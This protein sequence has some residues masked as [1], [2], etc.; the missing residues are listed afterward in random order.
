MRGVLAA[1]LL[2]A[3]PASAHEG[4]VHG[5]PEEAARHRAGDAPPALAAPAP[6]GPV[7]ALPFELGGPFELVDHEG[8]ARTQADPDGHLQ[9]LFFGYA[10]CP[11]ICAVAMPMMGQVVDALAERGVAATPVMITVDPERDTPETMDAPLARIHADFVGLTGDDAAL[12][13]AWDAFG[14]ERTLV[15]ELP[16]Y[17]PVYAHGGHVFLLDGAGEMLT[18]LPPVL[19]VEAMADIAMRYAEAG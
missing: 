19:S 17:G 18:V 10:N 2:A 16:E 8:A 12:K 14:I 9:L 1:A 6:S 11:S 15:A 3:L 7:T 13:A 4:V 5:S